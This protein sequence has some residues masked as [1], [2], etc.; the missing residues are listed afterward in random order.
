M[1]LSGR[2][3]VMQ[4]ITC[5]PLPIL[6]L[7]MKAEV[8]AEAS[9]VGP[10]WQVQPHLAGAVECTSLSLYKSTG[11][12]SAQWELIDMHRVTAL[13]TLIILSPAAVVI[14]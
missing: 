5:H 12:V 1:P 14:L 4:C 3:I 2:I 8:I 10:A 7:Y 11:E 6:L 9:A 13:G